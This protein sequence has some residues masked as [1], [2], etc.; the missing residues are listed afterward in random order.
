MKTDKDGQFFSFHQSENNFPSRERSNSQPKINGL[1]VEFSVQSLEQQSTNHSFLQKKS[2][3]G[4]RTRSRADSKEKK[5][6]V[7][8]ES[9][10]DRTRKEL[11][12]LGVLNG[13]PELNEA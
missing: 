11:D 10:F 4:S 12:E 7:P 13:A 6:E 8:K 5:V 1:K 2:R 9:L 3:K